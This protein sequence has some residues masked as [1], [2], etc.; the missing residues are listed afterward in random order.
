[1]AIERRSLIASLE[2]KGFSVSAGDHNFFTYR[3]LEGQKTSVWT[4]TSHGS[5]HKTL[6][7]QLVSAM[8][9]QCG[10]NNGQFAR[11]VE[12]PLSREEYE[13]ILVETGRIKP[14]CKE[15]PPKGKK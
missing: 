4:K 13:R 11:F 3:T 5:S 1:M 12:C 10:L 2:K 14:D 15:L 9:K 7:D 6:G 8:A